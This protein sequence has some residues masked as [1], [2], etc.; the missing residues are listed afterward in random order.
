MVNRVTQQTPPAFDQVDDSQAAQG[1]DDLAALAASVDAGAAPGGVPPA[2][3]AEAKRADQLLT[4]SHATVGVV[5]AFVGPVAALWP[6]GAKVVSCYGDKQRHDIG[7][8][9]AAFCESQGITPGEWM[10]KWGPALGLFAAVVGPAVPVIVE[11]AKAK[12]EA[13]KPAART[14]SAAPAAPPAPVE[15]AG[16]EGLD[17]GQ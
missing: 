1:F 6:I 14:E 17:V 13:A 15:L 3:Q 7:E 8:A 12:H 2:V 5:F 11:L 4:E 16:L 9:L 10:A